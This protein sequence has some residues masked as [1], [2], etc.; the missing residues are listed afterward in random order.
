MSIACGRWWAT[1]WG[2]SAPCS[3]IQ[4]GRHCAGPRCG[5]RHK[6]TYN[7]GKR[8]QRRSQQLDPRASCSEH[9]V[10]N[11]SRDRGR[12][13]IGRN[14]MVGVGRWTCNPLLTTTFEWHGMGAAA[15]CMKAMACCK[16]SSWLRRRRAG[17]QRCIARAPLVAPVEEALVGSHEVR[18]KV[19]ESM[20][21]H[22]PA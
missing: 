3:S 6:H 20:E 15:Q 22:T 5:H 7:S 16:G 21:R 11:T 17:Q 9:D 4:C 2:C 13:L 1:C 19:W 12:R 14:I 18:V 10:T 8:T